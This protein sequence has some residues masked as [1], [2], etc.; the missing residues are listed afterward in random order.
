[1]TKWPP[2]SV[3]APPQTSAESSQWV[4]PQW[5]GWSLI[6]QSWS[7]QAGAGGDRT[8]LQFPAS[9]APACLP[10]PAAHTPSGS[11]FQF[12]RVPVD[13]R[14]RGASGES[15]GP[16]L[17]SPGGTWPCGWTGWAWAPAGARCGATMASCAL[18]PRAARPP[19][20][21]GCLAPLVPSLAAGWATAP[22]LEAGPGWGPGWP[23]RW[24]GSPGWQPPPWGTCSG[25]RWCPGARGREAPRPDGGRRMVTSW[26][27]AAAP[28]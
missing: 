20:S 6:F 14:T 25:R 23:R 4:P 26:P 11:R 22:R 18:G 27:A 2:L 12:Q 15:A 28:S 16:A 3:L 17:P 5:A 21:P 1:M 24:P 9:S 13:L 7:G 19:A 10:L 8:G